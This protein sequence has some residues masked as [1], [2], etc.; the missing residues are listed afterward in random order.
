MPVAPRTPLI[1]RPPG[2]LVR[3]SAQDSF[4]NKPKIFLE[5]S[6]PRKLK[7]C[8][9]ILS[10]SIKKTGTKYFCFNFEIFKLFHDRKKANR[11]FCDLCTII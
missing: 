3:Y 1:K 5:P 7:M 6:G 11:K 2:Q 8:F 10:R 4:K 9:K